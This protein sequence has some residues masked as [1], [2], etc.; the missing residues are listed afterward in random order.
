M[1]SKFPLR[2]LSLAAVALVA[3]FHVRA[4][5][6]SASTN[7]ET[8]VITG[9]RMAR[10]APANTMGTSSF[11]QEDLQGT[12]AESLGDAISALAGTPFSNA[13]NLSLFVRGTNSNQLVVTI[14]GL[15]IN[16]ATSG[17][18]L[19]WTQLPISQVAS[20]SLIESPNALY[21]MDALGGVLA[22][23]LKDPAK[24][25]LG[26]ALGTQGQQTL[27][28]AL[29]LD[30]EGVRSTLSFQHSLSALGSQT[31]ASAPMAAHHPDTDKSK[32]HSFTYQLRLDQWE[33]LAHQVRTRSDYDESASSTPQTI[34]NNSALGLSTKAKDSLGG[35]YRFQAGI[36]SDVYEAQQSLYGDQLFKTENY[37]LSAQRIQKWN[38]GQWSAGLD[39]LRQQVA[40]TTAFTEAVR[41]VVGAYVAAD[42][43]WG[44]WELSGSV[45][46]DHNSQFGFAPTGSTSGTFHFSKNLKAWGALGWAFKAPTFNDMYTP[47]VDY[48]YVDPTW[49]PI[50]YT[51]TGNPNLKPE[52]DF[53]KELGATYSL[54]KGQ[55][56]ALL[57]QHS[58]RDL[59]QGSNGL[60]DDFPINVKGATTRGARVL[61]SF[62]DGPWSGSAAWTVLSTRNEETQ[63]EL[64]RRAKQS[65]SVQLGY[66]SPWGRSSV[67]LMMVGQRWDDVANTKR[68]E[69]ATLVNLGHTYDWGPNHVQLSLRN[70]T[71][72]RTYQPALGYN[73]PSRNLLLSYHRDL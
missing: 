39:A 43:R 45:R 56:T 32:T 47:F 14:N 20:V 37:Q 30:G 69:A 58:I 67:Q 21:G 15:R 11:T 53:S 34:Q 70:V 27:S 41:H 60:E 50:H 26:I 10:M 35:D 52:R 64:R 62:Q 22:I 65:G 33:L 2:A 9:T 17:G 42:Q 49:G 6:A 61:A 28:G 51:Y 66:R 68:L 48:S 54:E 7:P 44:D 12:G 59:I 46:G 19:G 31:N 8:V 38:R 73:H 55:V 29:R 18:S 72:N 63:L 57:F 25:Q 5:S 71:N 23:Q 4:Q 36:T 13:G 16:E 40:S 3:S 1:S 24:N